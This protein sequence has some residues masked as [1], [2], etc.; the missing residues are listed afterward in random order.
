MSIHQRDP[1][2]MTR[3]DWLT[4]AAGGGA[5]LAVGGVLDM[6]ALRAAAQTGARS[7]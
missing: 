2:T 7:T 1:N 6:T 4:R 3:R 5:G